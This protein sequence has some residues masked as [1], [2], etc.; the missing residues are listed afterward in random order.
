MNLFSIYSVY[1]AQFSFQFEI[2]SLTLSLKLIARIRQS[3]IYLAI[4]VQVI[5]PT[6]ET[7]TDKTSGIGTDSIGVKGHLFLMVKKNARI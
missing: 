2:P 1:S 6:F 3:L 5:K 7:C 4:Y